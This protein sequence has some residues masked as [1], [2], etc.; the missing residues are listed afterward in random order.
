VEEDLMP[1]QV[2]GVTTHYASRIEDVLEIALPTSKSEEK[3]DELVREEVLQGLAVQAA[4]SGGH[5]R[6]S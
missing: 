1:E 4:P 6:W 5:S 2:D 3:Q